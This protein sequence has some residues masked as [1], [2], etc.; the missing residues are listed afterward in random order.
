VEDRFEEEELP[1]ISFEDDQD[2]ICILNDREVSAAV[3]RDGQIKETNNVL[4][5][6]KDRL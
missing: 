3:K 2:V 5:L 4:C 1:S 6:V